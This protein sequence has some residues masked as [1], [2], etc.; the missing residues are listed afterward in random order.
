MHSPTTPTPS[1]F[2]IFIYCARNHVG[3]IFQNPTA[4][5][6]KQS[7]LAVQNISEEQ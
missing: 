6:I 4:L 2:E 1:V 5:T 3:I 7:Y